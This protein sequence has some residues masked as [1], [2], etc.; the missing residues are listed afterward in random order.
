[1]GFG[2][3]GGGTSV[4]Q[5]EGG[6]IQNVPLQN[7]LTGQGLRQL[8]QS[9]PFSYYGSGHQLMPQSPL[10]Q[11]FAPGPNPTIFGNPYNAAHHNQIFGQAGMVPPGYQQRQ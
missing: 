10:G 3:G 11:V 5:T 6:P 2:G 9:S 4:T 8:Q 1:M 7:E